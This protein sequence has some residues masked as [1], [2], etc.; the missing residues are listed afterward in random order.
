MVA[1]LP[2]RV[3]SLAPYAR[4]AITHF[5]Q[6]PPHTRGAQIVLA[7][8]LMATLLVLSLRGDDPV[9]TGAPPEPASKPLLEQVKDTAKQLAAVAAPEPP[10]PKQMPESLRKE[11]KAL[12]EASSSRER[13]AAGEVILKHRP[14]DDVLPHV[15]AIAELEVARSCKARK[16][17]IAKMRK[18][19]DRRYLVPLERLSSMPRSGCGFLDLSDCYACI[20]TDLR[21]AI[22]SIT[23]AEVAPDAPRPP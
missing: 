11:E 12:V 2:S 1:K 7:S 6:Q 4:T 14:E 21:V 10:K 19:A 9:A 22:A 23:T 15:R 8:A 16:Q 5:K 20:R 3:A 13:R 18:A 17:A